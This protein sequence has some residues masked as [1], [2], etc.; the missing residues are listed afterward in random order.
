[1][2]DLDTLRDELRRHYL[3]DEQAA[4]SRLVDLA[5]LPMAEREPF[6][7]CGR[8]RRTVRRSSDVQMME[9]FLSEY[10]LS[11]GE[12]VA[13]MCLAEALLRVPDAETIDD[14]IQDKIAPRDWRRISGKSS[15]SSST[16]RP[17]R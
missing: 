1:M 17:G 4:L 6:G 14:L 2:P 5:Q 9:T 15:S 3:P 10:G 12:G 11:T 7:A 8:A 16:P 13:L